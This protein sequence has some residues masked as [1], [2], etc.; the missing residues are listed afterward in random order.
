MSTPQLTLAGGVLVGLLVFATTVPTDIQQPGT[1]PSEVVSLQRASQCDNC[2]GNYAIEHEPYATWDSSMMAHAGRDPLFWATMAIAEQDFDGSGDLCL[3]CHAPNGWV[4]GFSTPTDGSALG[5]DHENGVECALCHRMTN[6]DGLE[7]VGVQNPPFIANSGGVNPE[8]YLGSG[9]YVL[10]DSNAR[11][12]PYSN[13]NSN[14]TSFQSNFHR[15]SEICGTCH[16][17]SNPLVGDL[18][19][20]H[21]A[22]LPLPPGSFSGVPGDPVDGKAAFNNPPYAYGVVE[23]TFSEHQ[24]SAFA[25]LPVSAYPLLPAD[26]QGG[27]LQQAYAAAQLAGTGGNFEDG[28]IRTFSCQSCHMMPVVG[29][30]ANKNGAPQRRDLAVHDLAGGSTWIQDAMLYLDQSNRLVLGGGLDAD[31]QAHLAQGQI[32]ARN[33]LQSAAQLE[34]V[35]KRLRIVNRT[36]HKLISGYPEGRRMWVNIRWYDQNQVMLREDG[37]YGDLQVLHRGQQMTVRTLLD[38]RAPVF[39]VKP[40][41][42]QEWANQLISVGLKPTMVLEYDPVTGTPGRTL[43]DLAAMPDG[44]AIES[45]HFV[46][47]NTVLSDNRIPPLGFSY[48]EALRR[49]ILPVPAEQYGNPGPGGEYL[50][51]HESTLRPPRGAARAEIRLLYQSTS[52]EYIQFLDLAND[53]SVAFLAQ[54][55]ADL[56]DAWLNTGMAEPE[57]MASTS[58][59][60]FKMTFQPAQ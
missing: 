52:W 26:L 38:H 33:M 16:D 7:H 36:G 13:V 32:Q 30:G 51:W 14:H 5:D 45:F 24:A 27:I 23:R 37:A 6:P 21:G 53:G 59:K 44:S 57:V 43:A 54:T 25:D 46:L 3:R 19:H 35:G 56:L 8:P 18:A 29:K 12:G 31:Q 34:V 41:M 47:N 15:E 9:M 17:V 42:T 39:Q 2:H 48:D 55:G 4:D 1:Q 10:T 22:F 20:N 60:K 58:W 40:G 11:L 50:Y 28:T 49:N